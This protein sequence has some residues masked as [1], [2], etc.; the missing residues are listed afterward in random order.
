[1]RTD[2]GALSQFD[3]WANQGEGPDGHGTVKLCR[4][5]N[6]GGW[7][8]RGQRS[9]CQKKGLKKRREGRFGVGLQQGRGQVIL[10]MAQVNSASTANSPATV[11]SD[12]NLKMPTF[13]RTNSTS[14]IS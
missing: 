14:R 11:A 6:Q 1:M 10:R 2:G 12:L 4:G 7:V 8:N 13:I 3:V 9:I 5:I